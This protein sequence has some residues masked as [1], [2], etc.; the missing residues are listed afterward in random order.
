MNFVVFA[1]LSVLLTLSW[2]YQFYFVDFSCHQVLYQVLTMRP[3]RYYHYV[4][5]LVSGRYF[6]ETSQ[7]T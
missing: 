7:Q 4:F 6:Y 3:G 2:Y 1:Q 5:M